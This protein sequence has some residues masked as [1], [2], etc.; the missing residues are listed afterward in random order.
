MK[1]DLRPL[2]PRTA[3]LS[4]SSNRVRV[5]PCFGTIYFNIPLAHGKNLGVWPSIFVLYTA[6]EIGS[7]TLIPKLQLSVAKR[8]SVPPTHKGKYDCIA[9]GVVPEWSAGRP[10]AELKSGSNC[11]MVAS[12]FSRSRTI[13]RNASCVFSISPANW[14]RRLTSPVNTNSFTAQASRNNATVGSDRMRTLRPPKSAKKQAPINNWSSQPKS[15]TI[16]WPTGG[17]MRA[18]GTMAAMTMSQNLNRPMYAW[19]SQY[20]LRW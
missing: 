11:T 7:F 13:F 15:F 8:K 19:I 20:I 16:Y 9:H 18:G 17:P 14:A 2:Y 5:A 4:L 10:L 6:N 1:S 3:R 12:R